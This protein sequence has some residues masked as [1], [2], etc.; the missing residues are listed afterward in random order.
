[1]A[2]NKEQTVRRSHPGHG[3]GMATGEKAKDFKGSI[4]RLLR[5]LKP[6]H[7]FIIISLVLAVLGSILSI[8]TPNKLSLLTDEISSGL[9]INSNN[10]EKIS[11]HIAD[12]LDKEILKEEIPKILDLNFDSNLVMEVMTS[13]DV[14]EEEKNVFQ[15]ALYNLQ[16][17]SNNQDSLK[18]IGNLPDSILNII[19]K[20]DL[21]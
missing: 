18:N 5:E 9:M 7:T 21:T 14:T 6:F 19:L 2:S 12:C 16:D 15:N 1:M 8:M 17:I 20:D 4:S 11:T 10:L 13:S 3:P